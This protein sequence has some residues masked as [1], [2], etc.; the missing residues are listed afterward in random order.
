MADNLTREQRSYCMSQ[1]RNRDTGPERRIC[2]ELRRLG[3]RFKKHNPRVAGTP[4]I[5]FYRKKVAVFI[6]GDFWHGYRFPRWKDSLSPFWREKIE[7]NRKRD[8]RNFAS[9]R[10]SGWRVIRIWTSRVKKD[11][12][13]CVAKIVSALGS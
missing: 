9:L 10:R 1:V 6:D 8:A 4:D 13:A 12:Q 11:S 2:S 3:I 7:K 5:V